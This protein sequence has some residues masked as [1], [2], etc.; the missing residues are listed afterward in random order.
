MLDNMNAYKALGSS[1]YKYII[2]ICVILVL[3]F[4]PYKDKIKAYI[5]KSILIHLLVLISLYGISEI[6]YKINKDIY[7]PCLSF[8]SV[9][10][11]V[12]K[13]KINS[14]KFKKY[15]KQGIEALLTKFYKQKI[16]QSEMN[17]I[18]E[19]GERPNVIVIFTEGLSAEVLD[20]FN[21]NNL[22]L[23]PNLDRLY[24]KSIVFTNYYNHTAATFRGLRGELFSSHQYLGGYYGNGLGFGEIDSKTLK[25][26]VGETKLVSIIDILNDNGYHT[27][28]IN[29]E[30]SNVQ[31]TNYLVEFKFSELIS[32]GIEDRYL[33]DREAFTVL[34]N[35]VETIEQP[36]LLG[37]YNIGTH[38]G[39]D[40][41]DIKFGDG[42]D[43]ILN[44]FHN[45]DA[46][47]GDFFDHF[48]ESNVFN[49]TL[50]I[51]TTDHATYNS[52][53]Y[54]KA[55]RSKQKYFINTIPLFIYYKGIEHKI[56]DVY[57]KNSINLTP[58]ILDLLNID[59]HENYFLGES[60]FINDKKNIQ[61]ITAIGDDLFFTGGG[62]DN[63]IKHIIGKM[64]E[65]D[66]VLIREYYNISINNN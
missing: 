57:G 7:F 22:K 17:V 1:L 35:T 53:E 51:F 6:N 15:S 18:N 36:F 21:T 52:T 26:R 47:F 34:K 60:L 43:S 32:G 12:S 30:P 49:N 25:E 9:V 23:T 10:Y 55:M 56:I 28:F 29:T 24:E 8:S 27:A 40:S 41:P 31:F 66:I 42:N 61:L 62:G 58:T 63:I 59:M 5:K 54:L 37:L 46:W 16:P 11:Q 2:T 13:S 33:S 39:F 50:L 19:L 20:V 45:F 38:H 65:E 48:T 64:Y 14:Y 3:S 44:K 4:L